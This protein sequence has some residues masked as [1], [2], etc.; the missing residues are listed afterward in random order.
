MAVQV[1]IGEKPENPNE[2]RAIVALANG[3][4]RLDGLYLLLANFN[5]GGRTIDLVILKQDAIFVIELKHCDG[6]IYGGVNGPWYIESDNGNRKRLNPGRKNPYNQ[7]VSYYYSFINFLNEHR[8][9]F[10]SAHKAESLNFRTSKR[11]IVIAPNLQAGSDV[12][13]DWKVDIRGLDELPTY[14]V[15]ERSAEIE[16]T[17]EEIQKIPRMLRCTRWQE[18]ND[19]LAGVMPN[20]E[21]LPDEV[22][23]TAP[24]PAPADAAPAEPAPTA[25]TPWQ[26]LR[27]S[28]RTTAGRL[29]LVTTIMALVLLVLLVSRPT[30]I[31]FAPMEQPPPSLINATVGPAGGLGGGILIADTVQPPGCVWSGFQPVGKRWDAA[32]Q[33]WINVGIDWTSPDLAPEVIVTLE[34]V[35]YCGDQIVLTWSV[36]N[37]RIEPVVFPLRRDNIEI[38]DT[39]GNSYIIAD[40][41]SQPGEIRVAPGETDRGKTIVP[42]PISQ[43]APSLLVRLKEQPFG[44]ASWLVSLEGE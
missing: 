13:L 22:P 5:V 27:A 38:R 40:S 31:V 7:V 30:R 20:W 24:A 44:E 41:K 4:E 25:T 15:T 42:R 29:A 16:F 32:A 12:E 26:K 35:A 33:T 14:L 11:V 37:K 39:L 34:Q 6:K 2:R 9:E 1:W 10:L 17:D 18:I 3:L 21:N 23:P 8:S 19:L 28:L 43:N 36:H